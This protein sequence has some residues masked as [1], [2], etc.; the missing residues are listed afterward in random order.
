[1]EARAGLGVVWLALLWVLE[2][3]LP[4][5]DA[6]AGVSAKV[7]H[8]ARNFAFAAVNLALSALFFAGLFPRVAPQGDSHFG[9]LQALPWRGWT[10][11]F[12]ALVLLDFVMYLWHRAN[13]EI[14]VLWRL[15][16]MHHSEPKMNTSTAL[17]FHPGEIVLS[18]LL[19]LGLIP[20][21]GIRLEQLVL[22]EGMLF[23]VVVFHHSNLSLPR[24]LDYGLLALLVTPAMHR[25][26]HSRLAAERSA[27][28]GAVL[29]IWD[30]LLRSFR[31]R[32]D[33][34]EVR[35]GLDELDGPAWQSLGGMLRTPFREPEAGMCAGAP[36][37]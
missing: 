4:Y 30:R 6:F 27:N 20:V 23:L 34:H 11:T 28:Y 16:R 9:L 35:I 22:Y 37:P 19:R 36:Q 15:H 31:V 2:W 26:H 10:Q 25:V 24:W 3:R 8:D 13:H 5:F 1:M 7:R 21:F 33:A 12:L 29:P 32:H 17:R 18:G 14:P